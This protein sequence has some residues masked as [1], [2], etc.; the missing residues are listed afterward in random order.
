MAKTI[1]SPSLTLRRGAERPASVLDAVESGWSV[2]A[3]NER[4]ARNHRQAWDNEQRAMAD[5]RPWRPAPILSWRAWIEEIWHSLVMEG[6]TRLILLDEAQEDAVWREIVD[7]DRD[8]HV[9]SN[10]SGTSA[11]NDLA[12]LA[13]EAAKRVWAFGAEDGLR[14][15]ATDGDALV[16]LRWFE[17]F[18]RRCKEEGWVGRARLESVLCEVLRHRHVRLSGLPRVGLF[19]AGWEDLT[20][21]GSALVQ[22]LKQGGVDVVEQRTNESSAR[23]RILVRAED[24]GEELRGC[25]RWV[26]AFLDERP[27][28]RVAIVV[29]RLDEERTEI[30]RV[31]RE[32]VSPALSFVSAMPG[33]EPWEIGQAVRLAETAMAST[34]LTLL[35]WAARPLEVEQMGQM[36]LAGSFGG[37]QER[38]V[39]AEFDAGELR[40]QLRLRPEISLEDLLRAVDR[41]KRA[42]RLPEL[43]ATLR[44]MKEVAIGLRGEKRYGDW[45]QQMAEF[46]RAARWCE[47]NQA[48]EV[49]A[50]LARRWEEA[51]QALASLDLVRSRKVD[52]RGALEDLER[53]VERTFLVAGKEGGGSPVQV[54]APKDATCEW[55]DAVWF[56]R[57]GD[58]VWPERS[59]IH[60]L[61]PLSLQ[62]EFK[63]PGGDVDNDRVAARE[64]TRRIVE[65]AGIVV[66]SYAKRWRD[67]QQKAASVVVEMLGV[68]EMD[69]AEIVPVDLDP[70]DAPEIET[71]W[72]DDVEQVGPL[73]DRV[74]SGGA[75]LL[76]F[77]AACGFQAFAEGRLQAHSLRTAELGLD[78]RER[79]NVIHRALELFWSEVQ[80]QDTLRSMNAGERHD[81]LGRAVTG[82]LVEFARSAQTPWDSAYMEIVGTRIKALLQAWLKVELGRALR[83]AVKL[84]EERMEDVRV[85]P[86]RLNL[87]IDR[88]DQTEWGEV[89]IDY[90]TGMS[91]SSPRGWFGDRMDAPQLP[92]YAILRRSRANE[93]AAERLEAVAF[94]RVVAGG[95][96][97]LHGIQDSSGTLTKAE[98]I[99]AEDLRSQV[100]VWEQALRRLAEQYAQGDARVR[101]KS[102]PGTCRYCSQRLLC[103]VNATALAGILDAGVEESEEEAELG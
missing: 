70:P 66:C 65:S 68:D 30:D 10:A 25:A 6:G 79:G 76:E 87:R 23:R 43:R 95:D 41:S 59:A 85:G 2:V 8:P 80:T 54:I 88:V 58:R 34:A 31:F 32:V 101:P 91:G 102:F 28:A 24:E 35:G 13:G 78:A 14:R 16:F 15:L 67:G 82:A 48:E 1:V 100:E 75:R 33:S 27:Q 19:L 3:A 60:P 29:P 9:R 71:E 36:L 64:M 49:G 40:Q 93:G 89:L 74:V 77:Q 73:P 57:A 22:V 86:L 37:E 72:I 98:A 21:A 56:L 62:R 18:E 53:I 103:R 5:S 94:G 97:H 12:R 4:I 96:M 20:P 52:F 83:F 50:Q 51:L 44:E 99:D 55:F 90:K 47:K 81:A 63:M 26:R 92:L 46:L 84:S 42:I 38:A 39:R 17:I 45:A 11:R 7:A 61:L 69:I